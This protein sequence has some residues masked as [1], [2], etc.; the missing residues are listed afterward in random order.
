MRFKKV[1]K[2]CAESNPYRI[3]INMIKGHERYVVYKGRRILGVT[4]DKKEAVRI[5]GSD[6]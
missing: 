5:A 3:S 6:K 1:N 4:D 2:Y